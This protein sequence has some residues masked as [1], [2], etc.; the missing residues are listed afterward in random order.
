VIK[1]PYEADS[2]QEL[3]IERDVMVNE[4]D[5][6][7]AKGVAWTH[8]TVEG[9]EIYFISNQENTQRIVEVSLRGQGREPELYDPVTNETTV[10]GN[11]KFEKGRTI[12]PLRLEA[13]GSV[14]VILNQRTKRRDRDKGKNWTEPKI[15]QSLTGAWQVAFDSTYG[16]PAKP[17]QADSLFDW[18]GHS[19]P[20]IRYYSGTASYSQSFEWNGKGNDSRVWL[21]L[22]A[23]ANLAEVTV[24]GTPCGIAWTPPYRVEITKALKPGK[25]ELVI[26][27]T[28]TWANRLIGDQSL[29]EAQRVT[30]T[31]A[32]YRLEGKPLLEAGLLGPVN[33]LK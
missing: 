19:V 26:D 27:V 17:V 15:I 5:G 21:D 24:N 18:S 25:N 33:I 7:R 30:W 4:A 2:F 23:V 8:R 3:G 6:K 9:K 28:N 32:P 1:G 13:N 10:T 12:L 11:W 31:T 14:F 29:P 20:G 22:G 16:G